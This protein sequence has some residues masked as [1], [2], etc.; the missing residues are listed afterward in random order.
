MEISFFIKTDKD[1]INLD[2]EEYDKE[3][4]KIKTNKKLHL[5]LCEDCLTETTKEEAI[6]SEIL[7]V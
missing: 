2:C 5:E 4:I 7:T 6:G 1:L 3:I